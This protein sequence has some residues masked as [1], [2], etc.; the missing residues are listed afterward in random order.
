M[1]IF[2]MMQGGGAS[3]VLDLTAQVTALQ[4]QIAQIQLNK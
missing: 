4:A 1:S 3:K 2:N